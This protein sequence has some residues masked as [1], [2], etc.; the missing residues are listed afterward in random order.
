MRIQQSVHNKIKKGIG[1]LLSGVMV[2]GMAAGIIPWGGIGSALYVQAAG[3]QPSVTAYATKEQLMDSTFAPDENGTSQTIGKLTFGKNSDGNIQ[4]WYILGTDTGVSGENTII[5]AASPIMKGK[6]NDNRYTKYYRKEYGQYLGGD[7]VEIYANHYGGSTLRKNLQNMVSD[8]VNTYFTAAEKQLMNETTIT[9]SASK[10]G[11]KYTTSDKLYLPMADEPQLTKIKIGS[12][13]NVELLLDTYNN[14]QAWFWL[15]SIGESKLWD[16]L[17]AVL[18]AWNIT[19]GETVDYTHAVCPVTNLNMSTVLFASA[20]KASYTDVEGYGV[21]GSG[22]AMTLRLAGAGEGSSVVYNDQL[23]KVHKG[24]SMLDDA[25]LV[26]QGKGAINGTEQDWYYS[27]KIDGNDVMVNASDIA[28]KLG[29]PDLVLSQCRIWFENTKDGV[30][31]AYPATKTEGEIKN[32]ISNVEISD[33]DTP[34][35]GQLLDTSA[36]CATKGIK[37]TTPAVTWAPDDGTA[38]SGTD[39]TA[40]VTLETL[41]DYEFSDDVTATVNGK[42]AIVVKNENGTLMVSYTFVR[43]DKLIS[44]TTPDPITVANGTAYEDM[45]LPAKVNIVTEKGTVNEADVKWDTAAPVSGSYD[46]NVSTEQNVILKGTVTCPNN[47]DADGVALTTTITIT[48]KA[49]GAVDIVGAPI[50]SIPSDTYTENQIVTLHSSTEGATIYYTMDGSDPFTNGTVYTGEISVTGTE[51][52]PVTTII[53]AI[54]VKDDMQDSEMVIFTYII[55]IPDPTAAPDII[56]EPQNVT[57]KAGEKATFTVKAKGVDLTYQWQVDRNDDNGFVD[58]G[59]NSPNHTTD[60]TD[61]TWSGFKYQC[62]IRNPNGNATTQM[63]TLTVI[64]ELTPAEKPKQEAEPAGNQAPQHEHNFRW[65]TVQTASAAQDGLEELRCD[66]GM[67]MESSVVPASRAY[68]NELCQNLA[69]VM[70][71]GSVT[72]DSGRIYTISDYIIKRLRDRADVT[73]TITFEYNHSQYRMIIPAGVDYTELLEDQDYFY[74]YFYFA[75]KV[76]AKVENL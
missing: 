35:D 57:V 11:L 28:S 34:A 36:V 1:I 64:D 58:I 37:T 52:Q 48:I 66:C 22:S 54:A 44:I 20:A 7:P 53:K 29:L 38:T 27:K 65:V 17:T 33:I 39:Y 76:G 42:D 26:V 25:T 71:N 55:D 9:T 6:F 13:D 67:V 14:I 15:R 72:F 40:S 8:G 70:E 30:A 21:I 4:E 59:E 12:Q 56:S 18:H 45:K 10:R 62:I 43:K 47:V 5:F 16:W 49:A 50:A 24:K 31:Y 74:G 73:T 2:F 63:A 61:I 60:E 46:P 3:N 51:G 68:V 32:G 19:Y 41:D 69:A 23:I 75:K